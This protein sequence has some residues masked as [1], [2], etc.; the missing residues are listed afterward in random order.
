M[1]LNVTKSLAF[2]FCL[3]FTGKVPTSA[4]S[5][6]AKSPKRGLAYD[7][8]NASDLSAL[9]SGVSW[10]YNYTSTPNSG[11]PGNYVSTY[12]VDY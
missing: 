9:S 1:K 11:V 5:T 4:Q 7:L 10:W 3:L 6:S 2:A 12:G 8:S